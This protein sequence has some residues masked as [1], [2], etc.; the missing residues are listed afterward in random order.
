MKSQQMVSRMGAAML[1][2]ILLL[3]PVCKATAITYP[4]LNSFLYGNTGVNAPP[5]K[6][7]VQGPGYPFRILLPAN[8]NPEK[9][10]PVILYLHGG[11]ETGKDNEKHLKAGKNSANGGL[12]LV[13]TAE[14]NN[15]A[16]YPCIFVA[17]QMSVNNWYNTASV[18]AIKD[19]LNLLKTQYPKAVDEDRL[20]LTG[21]S[22][23][24]MG[25][26]NLPPQFNPNPFACIVPI[27]AF[28][29]YPNT[30]PKIPIWNFHAVNDPIESIYRGNRRPG[31]LGSDVI[32]PKLRDQGFSIIYTRYDTGGHGIWTTA[33]Q[34]PL[35]LPWM[36]AQRRGQAQQGIPGLSIKSSTIEN[37][38]LTLSGEVTEK[39]N[40]KRVGWSTSA[41]RSAAPKADGVGDGTTTFVSASS[42]FD[43]TYVGQR[44]G[45]PNRNADMGILYY[46]ILEVNNPTTLKLS[47]KVSAGTHTF[48]TYPYGTMENPHPATGPIDS[49]WKLTDIPVPRDVTQV[50]VIAEAP[51]GSNLGGLTTMNLTFKVNQQVPQNTNPRK[52]Q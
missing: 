8:F 45:I 19:L 51:T 40:F 31:E 52:E 39:A 12:A 29:I 16:D 9:K 37:G 6:S 15:Q 18:Q 34:H 42:S 10:Y 2:I 50:Q 13:A 3:F 26:W 23:G 21:L 20:Y 41:F 14:P 27:C 47:G 4:A 24:G 43:K 44:L 46:D 28:S 49:S 48:V 17:P 25:S 36:L 1:A 33:Y 5:E 38:M 22:S 11:G 7:F 35:L 32:V 30:T